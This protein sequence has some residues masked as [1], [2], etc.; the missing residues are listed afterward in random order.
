MFL[1]KLLQSEGL[2]CVAMLLQGGGFRHF[3]YEDIDAAQKQITVLD[4]SGHTVYLAQATF[5]SDKIAEAKQHN[6]AL[7]P[8]HA[9]SD[10]KKIRGQVNAL[11]LKNFFLDIDCGEKWPLKNQR[12]GAAA[13]KQFIAETGLPFPAVVNSGNGLYAHWILDEPI[14]ANK[15]R[16][17]AFL[18]KQVVASYSP[19]IGGDASRTSDSASVLRVPGVINRKPGRPEKPVVLIKDSEPIQFLDFT[20][21][22][23][24]AAR[25]KKINSIAVTA[26][27]PLTDINANFYVQQENNNDASKVADR[28]AQLGLMRSSG[29]DMVEPMWYACI[30]VLVF[31]ND[32]D[33]VAHE[34]SKGY[35]GYSQTETDGKMEQWRSS[36]MGPTTCAKFGSENAGG[37]VGCPHNG[38]IKSPITLG[39]PDPVALE[40]ASEQ[41]AAPDGFRRTEEGL[42]REEDGIW[43]K[44][45][46]QDLHIHCLAYDESL[47]YEVMIIRH[48]LP[49]E[50][51]MECTLRSSL[52]NDPKAFVTALSDNHIKVVGMKEKKCM[53]AFAES[54]QAKLQ[55]QRRMTMLLCQMGWKKARNDAAMFVLGRK[56][57]HEDG[58]I[59]DASLARNVPKAAEGFHSRGSLDKWVESTRVLGKPGMEPFAFALLAGGFGAPLMKFTGFDGALISLVGDSGAGKTLMLRMIQSVWGY[60]NDLMMLRD[61]TKNALISR[62]G[63]YGNLP[64]TI[65]EVSN[66]EGME[67]SDFTYR[68]TQGRDKARLTKN[69]EERRVLNTWNTV[70]VTTSNSSLVDKLSGAKHDASAE[71]NRIFEYQVSKHAEFQGQVTTDLYWTL[72]ENYGKAGEVYAA[73]LVKN[74]GKV[75]EKLETLKAMVESQAEVKGEERFWGAVVSAAIFGGLIAQELGLIRFSVT[76]VMSWASETIRNMRGDKQ[77]LSGD[78]VSILGQFLDAHAANRLVVKGDPRAREGCTILEAPRGSLDV[79]FEVDNKMQY[80]SRATV[81]SW[82]AKRYGSYTQIKN[83]LVKTGALI[84]PNKRK[85][86]GGGTFY[87]GA[88]QPTWEIDMTCPALSPEFRQSL[89]VAESLT[90]ALIPGEIE[91]KL[92]TGNKLNP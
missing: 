52:V 80:L 67:L 73:W 54:Y 44:F 69:A 87:G 6:K 66:I 63:V 55:R 17:V 2:Y 19:A 7:P 41:C 45:Y 21:A 51:K 14:Q 11:Y 65:D 8:G 50:G 70:A 26:P 38:K 46:D 57:F 53:V 49:Y 35:A 56:V 42:F 5:D 89:H 92:P 58:S 81:K 61:D 25:K 62:L 31:C 82:I 86:I 77:E 34:W 28:C 59:E 4:K 9:K 20:S 91:C 39:R 22:L 71:I 85:V 16:T 83:E 18:L 79:R 24:K 23:E 3:F 88:Q 76:D 60:H 33:A 68:I 72:H 36:G 48:H 84:N 37:C 13:L 47:G 90:K 10:R 64:L 15:W 27:K 12:E 75:K 1:A 40:V 30:G 78:A 43:F 29:G 32:G 74:T